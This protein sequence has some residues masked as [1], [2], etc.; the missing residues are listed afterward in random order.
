MSASELEISTTVSTNTQAILLLTAPLIVGLGENSNELLTPSEYRKLARFLYE[1]KYLPADLIAAGGND[2]LLEVGKIVN[3]DR[4]KRLLA[5]GFLLSQAIERWQARAIWVVS[6]AD[7][8]YPVRLKE[9]LR[10]IAA[11]V[12]YGCGDPGVLN[13]GGLAVVGS[14]HADPAIL[15]SATRIGQ[16]AARAQRT[17]I[18]GGARGID[19]AAMTG[20][21]DA[22]GN[23]VGVLAD[24]LERTALNRDHRSYLRDSQLVL[25]SPYDPQAGFN[26][27]NA[28]QRNKVIYALADAALVVQAEHGKGGTWAGATEQLDKLRLVPIYTLPKAQQQDTAFE[29]LEKKG[30]LKWPNP[31][32]PEDFNAALT[33]GCTQSKSLETEHLPFSADNGNQSNGILK[34]S[35]QAETSSEAG[36]SSIHA[37]EQLFATVRTLLEQL[38]GPQTDK[39]IANAL[40]VTIGQAKDWI[41]RLV[42]EGTLEKLSDPTRYR[43]TKSSKLF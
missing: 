33:A 10:D 24:S 36:S 1:N 23:A 25:V 3:S 28:M 13:A 8:D 20:A 12:L 41:K 26:I 29:A 6:K 18:S 43:S 38:D 5:R 11:P 27:G 37:S 14:R 22:G 16:L 35:K 32:T 9:R 34:E 31:T 30:A 39:E 42:K 2:L 21:L 4:L 7:N 15:E 17:I 40:K 19:Q